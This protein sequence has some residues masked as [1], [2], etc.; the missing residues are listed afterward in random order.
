MVRTVIH[1][2]SASKTTNC[3]IALHHTGQHQTLRMARMNR[4]IYLK[5]ISY[6]CLFCTL[7]I[8]TILP[9]PTNAHAQSLDQ[10][11]QL[12]E[13][14]LFDPETKQQQKNA[15]KIRKNL[16]VEQEKLQ[17]VEDKKR[18]VKGQVAALDK[19]RSRLNKLL[20]N[21]AKRIQQSETALSRLEARL[22]N[23]HRKEKKLRISMKQRS[24]AISEMLGL[25]QRMAR[26]PPPIM[27]THKDDALKMVRS[28]MLMSIM[29]PKLTSQADTLKAEIANLTQLKTNITHQSERLRVQNAEMESDRLRVKELASEKKQ[30]ILSHNVELVEFEKR[31]K[32]HGQSVASLGQLIKRIDHDLKIKTDLGAYDRQLK[33]DEKLAKLN[34][35]KQNTV[36]LSP[37][38]KQKFI[39]DNLGRIEPA[40]PFSK[41][42]HTLSLPARGQ[43]LRGFGDKMKHGN[44]S[45]GISISTRP[46]A[47]ITSPSDG[48]IVYAGKF[49]SY[50]QLLIINAGGG[51]HLLLAGLKEIDVKTAQFVL[52]GEPIGIMAEK[53]SSKK[54]SENS[55]KPVLYIEFRLNGRSINPKPWWAEEQISSIDI[56]NAS[57]T[58]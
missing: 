7:F 11:T 50:G 40:M 4:S 12:E 9:A 49:R 29:L 2:V 53:I 56:K 13:E 36:I 19:E 10:D 42:K 45:K 8:A 37:Q 17:E 52:A 18:G 38:Q 51:Y 46:G 39:S 57:T 35:G 33:Q 27:A 43:V 14:T 6:I 3:C 20:I 21:Y 16:A 41:V 25:L 24:G 22:I 1:K 26:N 28:A 23:L 44:I 55:S 5:K 15:A 34:I 48:W 31:V 32:Q 54:V 30:R 58:Q 47:Q